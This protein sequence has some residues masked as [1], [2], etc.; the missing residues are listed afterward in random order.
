MKYQPGPLVSNPRARVKCE[1][2][3]DVI[4]D[5]QCSRLTV[6]VIREKIDA[7]P[8]LVGTSIGSSENGFCFKLSCG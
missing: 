5:K 8:V 7:G 2:V 4:L 6:L 3:I 1:W